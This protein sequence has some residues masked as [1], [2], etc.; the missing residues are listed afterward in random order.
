MKNAWK[1][2]KEVEEDQN[3]NAF[4]QLRVAKQPPR[5]I[6]FGDFVKEVASSKKSSLDPNN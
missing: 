4:Q 6:K 3:R 1:R 5:S 2:S